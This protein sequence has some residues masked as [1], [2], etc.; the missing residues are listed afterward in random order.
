M[1]KDAETRGF[2]IYQSFVKYSAQKLS[3]GFLEVTLEMC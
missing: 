3:S 1:R 2:F